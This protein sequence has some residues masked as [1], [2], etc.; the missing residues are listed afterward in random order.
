MTA[1]ALIA[2]LSPLVL[3]VLASYG[4]PAGIGLKI[5]QILVPLGLSRTHLAKLKEKLNKPL[6]EKEKEA[7]KL[8]RAKQEILHGRS[9]FW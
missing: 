1:A 7:V 9:G 3:P 6:T 4:I 5:L 8:D 2:I